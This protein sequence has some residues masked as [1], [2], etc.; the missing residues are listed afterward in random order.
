MALAAAIRLRG[1]EHICFLS[2]GS[3]GTDGPTDAAG[4]YADGGTCGR[5]AENGVSPE[6]ALRNNDSYPALKA[7]GDLI[8]TG[9][10]G[11]NVNDLTLVLTNNIYM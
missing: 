8:V 6:E 10:T 3:D 4:G 1:E 5:M 2:V 7:A 11:T 9:P